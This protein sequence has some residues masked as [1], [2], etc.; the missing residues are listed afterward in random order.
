MNKG[1]HVGLASTFEALINQIKTKLSTKVDKNGT[2]RLM[3][4]AEGTK[5]AN[6]ES[7]AEVNVQTDWNQTN[8][9]ADDYLK[10]KP[11]L[12]TAAAK[13]AGTANG[14]A[15]LDSTGKVPSSQL[16]SYVDDVLEYASISSFPSSGDTGKI[17]VAKDTNK[18]YRWSGSEYVEIS[19]SLALGETSSTAYRGDRGKTAYDFSQ[20]P[21]TSN[22]A[23]NGTASAGS[24]NA[25]AR[26]DHV[27]PKDTSK[28]DV[29]GGDFTGDIHTQ[30]VYADGDN[31]FYV[32]RN[33]SESVYYTGLREV[34]DAVE[35]RSRIFYGTCSTAATTTAKAV[36]LAS[37]NGDYRPRSGDIFIITFTNAIKVSDP[38]LNINGKGAYPFRLQYS[39]GAYGNFYNEAG[40]NCI[41]R[42][43][44]ST[45][46]SI[47]SDAPYFSF[48]SDDSMA[49]WAVYN[50]GY[51]A[52]KEAMHFN[53]AGQS[54]QPQWL[55]GGNDSGFPEMYVWLTKNLSVGG[56]NNFANCSESELLDVINSY[57]SG[58]ATSASIK[59]RWPIGSKRTFSINSMPKRTNSDYP[60][61]FPAQPCQTIT[62]IIL[63]YEHDNL[64]TPINGK[65]KAL[66]TLG[67]E[68]CLEVKENISVDW[69]SAGGWD[70]YLLNTVLNTDFFGALPYNLKGAVKCVNK[71]RAKHPTDRT[72]T[73]YPRYIWLPAEK[74]ITGSN[75]YSTS[76]EGTRYAYYDSASKRIKKL[77]QF[78][79]ATEWW[80]ASPRDSHTGSSGSDAYYTVAIN[81]SGGVNNMAAASYADN[82]RGIAPHFCL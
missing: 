64:V 43:D 63:D 27:H 6:I 22:P 11:T 24:S 36:T 35:R 41:V 10:N 69:G 50:N 60:G 54:G 49:S 2:D 45:F 74:E 67:V 17:Y 52:G 77:G 33:D 58:N 68:N 30:N 25:W 78:G 21:Y 82:V 7:G 46:Y 59:A 56:I 1:D 5:L 61:Q 20:A 19:A 8:T 80:T 29:S 9:T 16:P 39:S 14:V 73:T 51:P 15:E 4:A 18:T 38:T 32:E 76:G 72:L 81:A 66:M 44:G 28:M 65:T 23:M 37:P 62:V 75:T 79:S 48:R 55:W 53:W 40:R 13:D 31:D 26:G 47:A 12:G 42:F 71:I 70:S 57:Y 34:I 3:T